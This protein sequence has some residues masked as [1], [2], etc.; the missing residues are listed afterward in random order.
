[1]M[2]M[3]AG[4][5]LRSAHKGLTPPRKAFVLAACGV[6]LG[7]LGVLVALD[8]PIIKNLWTP[9]FSLIVGGYSFLMLA[10]FY[11]IIDVKGWRRGCIF[12]EVVGLNSITI[13]MLKRIVDYKGISHFLFGGV[14]SWFSG[15]LFVE[16]LGVFTLCWLTCWFLNR[17]KI[18]LKI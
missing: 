1:M 14:A 16:S 11:W 4:D 9:S 8:C 5:L 3:F 17:Q 10:I 6:A 13:Y 2:G 18:Y 15:S 7:M 12:F